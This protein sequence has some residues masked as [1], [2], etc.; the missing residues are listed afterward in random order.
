MSS[1]PAPA[2]WLPFVVLGVGLVAISFGAIF[3][4]V[5]QA[6]GVSSLAVATWRLGF[7]ALI[8][9]PVA[10]LQARHELARLRA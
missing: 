2:R 8:I 4:R 10:L 3:A 1:S 9:T 7:A 5:A 6:E